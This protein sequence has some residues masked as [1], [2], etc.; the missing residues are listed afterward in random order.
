[1]T[2]T[3]EQAAIL[4]AYATR[5]DV[6]VEAGAGCGKTATLKLAATMNPNTRGRYLAFNRAIVEE[7]RAKFPT[8]FAASTIHSLAW[9]AKG[10]E[11]GHRLNGPRM[12][13]RQV[14]RRLGLTPFAAGKRTLSDSQVA[15][16]A[17]R[18]VVRFCQSADRQ[19]AG[20]H[21]PYVDGLDDPQADGRRG[22][23]ANMILRGQLEPILPVLWADLCNPGGT[24]PY[25]HEHYLKAWELSGP[26]I[27][28]DVVLLDEAQDVSPVLASIVDQQRG[29]AQSVRVGDANQAI[30]GF[31]GAIDALSSFDAPHRLSLSQSFRFGPGIADLANEILGLLPTTLR[32]RG[33]PSIDSMVGPATAPNAV[34]FRSNAGALERFLFEL[35]EGKRPHL[36]GGGEDI[37]SFARAAAE[38]KAGRLT[39]HPDLAAFV[40]WGEVQEYVATDAMGEDMRLLVKLVDRFGAEE[41]AQAL[42]HMTGENAAS[43]VLSTAHKAK[44]R[45]WSSVALGPDFPEEMDGLDDEAKRLLYVA[46]T[47]AEHV[48]DTLSVGCLSAG[49]LDRAYGRKEEPALVAA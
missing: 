48:L 15:S 11:F 26:R 49:A 34:L 20:H 14:A 40:T 18:A 3:E 42:G 19:P 27:E 39:S 28:A 30:Y 9:A 36:V 5:A 32:L 46:V 7:A 29:H 8:N 17:L 37:A 22:W 16:I 6:V 43:I 33:L 21:V 4:A 25:R 1:M 44:G 2:P 10:R 23:T 38:I 31:T 24:M 47:R 35:E 12:S 13:S 41:I 45:Q